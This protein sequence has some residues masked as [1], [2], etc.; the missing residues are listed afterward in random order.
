[1]PKMAIVDVETTGLNPY[2]HTIWSISVRLIGPGISRAVD[3]KCRPLAG[4]EVDEKALEVGGIT[5]AKL[6][7]FPDPSTT[8]EKLEEALSGL[9]N[10]KNRKDKLLFVGYNARFDYDFLR[11]WF[12]R[13][14]DVYF[15]S[16]F[17]FPPLDVMDLAAWK[18]ARK[19]GQLRDFKLHTVASFMGVP[20]DA[21]RLHEAAY[22]LEL[23]MQLMRRIKEEW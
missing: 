8:K 2:S 12:E 1:M 9:V 4:T 10:K 22:D 3:L 16:W 18:L 17:W 6:D 5:Q 21:E 13:Q 19:R 7:R 11:Q 20:V 15:G 23:T 14:G